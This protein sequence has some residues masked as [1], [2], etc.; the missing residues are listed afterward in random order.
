[1]RFPAARPAGH[2]KQPARRGPRTPRPP[3]GNGSTPRSLAAGCCPRLRWAPVGGWRCRL[4]DIHV[5][6]KSLDLCTREA[7][8]ERVDNAQTP[9]ASSTRQST[10]RQLTCSSTMM[11]LTR[12]DNTCVTVRHAQQLRQMIRSCHPV[13]PKAQAN[14]G[15]NS[16]VTHARPATF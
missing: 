15:H 12:A 2:E 5:R 4:L 8:P 9:E 10:R 6:L 3:S 1:M 14:L 16:N 13:Q 11:R 7:V